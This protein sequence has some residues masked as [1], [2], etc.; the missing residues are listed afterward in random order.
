MMRDRIGVLLPTSGIAA[1]EA[2]RLG[3]TADRLGY[4][5]VAVG[6]VNTWDATAL[7]AFLAARTSRVDL[8]ASVLPLPSRSVTQLAVAGSTISELSGGRFTLGL[9]IGGPVVARWHARSPTPGVGDLEAAVGRVRSLLAGE[10]DPITGFRL[11]RPTPHA[12]PIHVGALGP[13]AQDVALSSADGV[14]LSLR[15]PAAVAGLRRRADRAGRR[16]CIVAIQWITATRDPD[17]AR[18]ELALAAL[19]YLALPG[20][21]RVLDPDVREAVGRAVAARTHDAIALIPRGVLDDI[22]GS[23]APEEVEARV[24]ALVA[25]GADEVRLM[26]IHGA[27]DACASLLE[28]IQP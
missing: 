17:R 10:R 9:A 7:L 2:M 15:G 21:N 25:A 26:P 20:Y 22:G 16:P 23:S 4:R 14:V 5:T 27:F 3:E 6:E 1:A 13:R 11:S 19:P 12:V 28:K 24:D 8:A 18:H